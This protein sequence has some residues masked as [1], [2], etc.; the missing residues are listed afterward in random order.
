MITGFEEYTCVLN[1][2]EQRELLPAIVQSMKKYKG[3]GHAIKNVIAV[4]ALQSKGYKISEARFRKLMHII[5]TSGMIEGIVATSKGYYIA[6]TEEEWQSYL[7]SIKERIEHIQ[8]L[9]TAL[10]E[11][12][13]RWRTA[14]PPP[15]P[16]FKV[17]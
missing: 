15:E 8:S 4:K 13:I 9:E 12:Y 14:N 1:E 16:F 7:K 2:Y 11:Q 10:N 17:I 5:R 6:E 3:E